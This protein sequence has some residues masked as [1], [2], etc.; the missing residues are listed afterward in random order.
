MAD[1]SEPE[2]FPGLAAPTPR[3]RRVRA[4][5]PDPSQLQSRSSGDPAVA[6]EVVAGASTGPCDGAPLAE[7]MRPASLDEVVGRSHTVDPDGALVRTARALGICLGD[8]A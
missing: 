4:G 8:A 1:D 3:G 2:L 6:T 5:R 7:R